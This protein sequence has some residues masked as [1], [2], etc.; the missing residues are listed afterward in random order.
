MN[1]DTAVFSKVTELLGEMVG[2]ADLLGIEITSGTTFHEDLGLESI[3]LVTFAG[4][5]ADHFGTEVNLAEFLAEKELDEV[6]GLRVGDIA[7][8]VESKVR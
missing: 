3:D 4:I 8:Y 5:L 6:I 2:G 7:D 1:T